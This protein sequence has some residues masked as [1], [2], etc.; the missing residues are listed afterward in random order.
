[1]TREEWELKWDELFKVISRQVFNPSKA[2]LLTHEE[3][4]KRYGPRPAEEKRPPLWLHLAASISGVS[5]DMITQIWDWLNGKKLAIGAAITALSWAAVNAATLLPAFG[6]STARV[7]MIV[8]VL[9]TVVG[10]AHKLYKFI[11]K[12]EHA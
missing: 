3:M 10:V 11:Y 4:R 8:G 9:T 12:E 6:V 5:W 1:M 7:T 2:M